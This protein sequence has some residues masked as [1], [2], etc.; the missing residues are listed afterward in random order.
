MMKGLAL[1]LVTA[2]RLV[3]PVVA[4]GGPQTPV[5]PHAPTAAAAPAAPS[6]SAAPAALPAGEEGAK[7]A[8]EKSPRHH[9]WVD[10]AIPG[11]KTKVATFVAYPERAD[12]AP[13]VL[14][15]HEIFGCTEW[16]RGVGDRLAAEGFLA[17]VPDLISGLGSNGGGTDSFKAKEE[18]LRA[19]RDLPAEDVTARLDAVSKW[20]RSQPSA[21][22]KV[23]TIGFCW[24]GT[25][26]FRYATSRPELAAAVVYYGTPPD[27]GMAAIHAPVI[28]FY[29]GDD[30]RVTATVDSTAI[31][32]KALGKSYESHVYPGAGHGF[33]RA[34]DGR[35]GANM[36]ATMQ[37]WPATIAF[38]RKMLG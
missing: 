30:A 12:K 37:A 26:S 10:V 31:K 7:D 27:S 16:A 8:L 32:M 33:L 14:V 36:N 9:E 24:G 22:G 15:I 19:V 29:G 20:A 21:S 18:V 11:S 25:Q 17:V 5:A 28:G 38:L 13:V 34:Q 3:L 4:A 6:A 1:G 2:V 35:N 23:A